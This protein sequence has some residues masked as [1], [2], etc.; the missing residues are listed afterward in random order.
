M[1]T[2]FIAYSL[3]PQSSEAELKVKTSSVVL[4]ALP[5]PSLGPPKQEVLARDPHPMFLLCALAAGEN[6]L[7]SSLEHCSKWSS[8]E[9]RGLGGDRMRDAVLD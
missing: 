9:R 3:S 8:G 1:G 5:L 7:R 4:L 6:D 2:L